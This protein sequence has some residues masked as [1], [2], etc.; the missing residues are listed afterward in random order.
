MKC[1]FR[2]SSFVLSAAFFLS[3]FVAATQSAH[4]QSGS[5]AIQFG[6]VNIGTTSA[7]IAV[8]LAFNNVS[9]LGAVSVMTAGSSGLDFA[10]VGLDS[11][12]LNTNGVGQC[13]VN[14]TFTPRFS[15]ARY[16]AVV[17][18][19]GSGSVVATTY[20][21]GTGVGP[22]VNFLAGTEIPVPTSTLAYPSLVAVDGNGDVFIA[23]SGNNRV[24][25]EAFSNGAFSESIIMTSALAWPSGIAV[26]ASGC[27]Y[28]ADSGNNR[29]LK[30]TLSAG[31]YVESTIQTSTLNWPLAV[32]V[33]ASGN[34]YIADSGNNRILMES[35]SAGGYT[36]STVSTSTLSYPSGVAVDS[37][38]NIYIADS[39]NNRALVEA[40]SAGSYEE[41]TVPT[42]ALNSP[43]SVSVDD[44]NNIYIADSGNNRV[45]KEV[46]VA[47]NYT[48][49]TVPSSA[50]NWPSSVVVDGLGNVYIA[51]SGNNR[52]L[53]EDLADPPSLS[54]AATVPGSTS[55]DSPRT[56]TLENIGNAVLS[57]P[58]PN[59]GSNPSIT[60][61]FSL[62]MSGASACPYVTV[63]P[64]AGT[65]DAGQSCSLPTSFVPTEAGTFS[66]SLV[67]TDNSLN[68]AASQTIQLSGVGTGNTQ[69]TINFSPIG[70]QFANSN[71]ALVASASSG[72]LVS[73]SST[74]PTICTVT[75]TAASLIAAGTCT[76]LASQSG[77]STYAAA[78]TVTQGFTVNL[79]PQTITF[80]TI[81]TQIINTS[82]PVAL[83]ATA[84]SGLPV[85]FLST[86]S[87]VC[88]ITGST[89]VL[90]ATG[91]CTIQASQAGDGIVYAA[92]STV[93]QSFA[94]ASANQVTATA[95]GSVNI[96]GTSSQIN[97]NLVFNV[98]G[99]VASATV[100][101][102]GATGLDFTKAGLG[103]CAVGTNYSAGSAC[104]VSV[105]FTPSFSGAR[106]GAVVLADGSGNSLA[107]A[108]LEGTGIGPQIDF[109]PG[110]EST[111]P[112]STLAYSAGVAQDDIGNLYI[113][114]TG[115]NRVLKETASA[116]GYT[117]S[118][119]PSSALT[120]PSGVA[121]DAAGN[122]YIADTGNSRV[123]KETLSAGS[124]SEST[125]P[126]SPLSWPSGVAVDGSGNVYVADT[127][128]NRVLIEAL[129]LGNYIESVI[130]T[131]PLTY[132]GA[133]AVDG[134]GNLYIAD[135]GNNRILMETVS[136]GS[137]TESV[138]Q[139][140]TLNYPESIAVDGDSN[141]FIADTYNNRVLKETVS[142]GSYVESTVSTSTLSGPSGVVVASNGN[143]AIA[144]TY[145]NRIL[146]EDLADAPS[147]SFAPTAPG[148]A[149]SDSPQTIALENNGNAVLSFSVPASGTDPNIPSN[150]ALNSGVMS[151]C[152]LLA[153]GA[154]A[155]GTLASGQSC[156]L[157]ISFTP[158]SSG[159]FSAPLI[160]TDN[161]LNLS[162][163][164]NI[165][166][167][168]TGTG[169]TQQ[170]I[171]FSPISP[172]FA[173]SFLSLVA[174]ASSG[175]PVSFVSATPSICSVSG[176]SASL[177]TAGT[178]TIQAN[179][180]GSP[181]YAPALAVAQS[182]TVTLLP[183]TITFAPISNQIINKSAP[184]ILSA[185]ASSGLPIVFTTTT[186]SVCTV[187]GS[188][189][190][191]AA[192]GTCTI[193]ANQ[194]GDGVVYAAAPTAT[195]SFTVAAVNAMTSANLGSVNVG[196]TSSPT[197]VTLN[198]YSAAIL[199]SISVLTQGATGLNF[200]SAGGGSCVIGT[201]YSAGSSCTVNVTFTPTYPGSLYGAVSLLDDSGSVIAGG[202]LQGTGVGPQVIFLPGGESTLSTSALAYP[203]QIAVDASGNVYIADTGNNRVLKETFSLGGYVESSIP[204][205]ALA[206]PTGVAIDGSGNLFI[207]DTVN[208]RVLRETLADGQFVESTVPTSALQNPAAVAADGNGN[209]YIADY[210]NN[211]VLME[212]PSSGSYSETV[213]PTSALSFPSGVAADASGNVYIADTYNSRV[214]KES[215]SSGSYTESTI[216][217]SPLSYPFGVA[218]D[219]EGNVYIADS[220]NNR[221]LK[222]AP[223]AGSYIET[224]VSTSTLNAPLEISGSYNGNLY[225]A[226]TYNNRVLKEDFADPPSLVFAN[227]VPGSTSSDSPQIVT[228]ENAG[229]A[230]LNFPV[231]SSGS[232]P[233]ISS[234]FTLGN[235]GARTCPLITSGVSSAGAL[236]AGQS[237]LLPV[238]FAPSEAGPIS[239]TLNLSDNTLDATVSQTIELNGFATGNT[240]QTIS[241]AS[242]SAQS[243]LSNVPLTATASS[244][245]T[246]SLA[247]TSPAICTVA[248][249]AASL[250]AAGNCTIQ[251]S[252][253][254]NSV[255]SPAPPVTQNFVVNLLPQTISFV[256]IATQMINTPVPLVAT[257]SSGLPVIFSSSTPSVCTVASSTA[258]LLSVGT[259][260][261]QATQPGDG[262]VFAPAPTATQSFTVTLKGN[263]SFGSINVGST[264]PAIS[265]TLDVYTAA[266]LGSVSVSTQG[267]SGL[268]F[269]V[270]SGGGTCAVGASYNSG[271]TCTVSA[272]FT[273]AHSGSRYGAVSLL[274]GS[275]NVI[276]TSYLQG[277]G[278]GPQ[279][280]FPPG[281]EGTVPNGAYYVEQIALD[282]NN[283][284]YLADA[285]GN[286]IL[287]E[288]FTSGSYS[289]SVIQTS[290]LA[291][292]Y[293]VSIDGN[294]N[295]Y[296]ADSGNNRILKETLSSGNYIE[297][298]ISTSALAYPD[299]VAVDGNGN[300]YISDCDNNRVLKETLSWGQYTESVV[301][302]SA[303]NCPAEIAVDGFGN[304]YFT[305]YY[306]N[307]VL[308]EAPSADT[309]QETTIPTS[310]LNYPNGIAVDNSGDIYVV[311]SNPWLRKETVSAGKYTE[312]I[313]PTSE[314]YS[315]QAVA[316]DSSGNIYIANDGFGTLLKED[317]VDPPSLSF[318]N[319]APG[320][321]SSDSPQ[322]VTVEN[323]GN[324]ILAFP[325]PSNGSNPAISANFALTSN[326]AQSCPVIESG[327]SA[328]GMLAAGQSCLL[329]LSFTP[330]QVGS[331][332]G[333]LVLTDNALN[334]AA[335]QTIQLSGSG[336]EGTQQTIT[337]API[338]GQL[339]VQYIS[340][341]ATA[342]SGLSVTLTSVTPSVCWVTSSSS[343]WLAIAGTCTIQAN[344]AGNSVY[345]PAPTVTQSFTVNLNSQTIEYQQVPPQIIN[346]SVPTT[347]PIWSTSGLPISLASMTP[348]VC[349]VPASTPTGA[350]AILL[351]AAGTCTIQASQPGDGAL[352]APAAAVTLSF[353]VEPPPPA[354]STRF[355]AANIG[356]T[357]AAIA[358]TLSFNA[359]ASLGG[360]SVVTQGVT[361]LDF[362]NASGGT[363]TIGRNYD[364]GASCTVNVTFSPISSGV[365]YGGVSLFDDSGN[366][367]ATAYVE[368]IGIGPQI[369]FVPGSES[370]VST[371]ALNTPFGVAVD[372][373]GNL[374]IADTWNSRLIK[375][376]VTS[377]GYVESTI[378]VGTPYPGA[379][380]IDGNGNLYIAD[381]SSNLVLKETVSANGYSEMVLQTSTLDYPDALAV[382]GSGNL[383]IT[384]SGNNRVLI[385][386]ST[387]TGYAETTLPTSALAYPNG[388]AVDGNGNIYI[389]DTDNDRVLKEGVSLSGYT[390]STLPT[391]AIGPMGVA[392][393]AG[394]SLY[395][396]D[397]FFQSFGFNSPA[398]SVLKE[399]LSAGTYIES[400][401]ATSTLSEPLGIAVDS[402]G[403]VYI[404]DTGNNRILKEDYADPPSLSFAST[405]V[406]STSGDS[407]QTVTFENVGNAA[408]TF[409]IPTA[410][411]NPIVPENFSLYSAGPQSCPLVVAGS[412]TVGILS[413][414]QNCSLVVSFMPDETGNLNG[415][416]VLTDN[417]LNAS[418][419]S[420]ATQGIQ[421]SGT[422][423]QGDQ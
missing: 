161:A 264:S 7:P 211:R 198:V 345:A 379:V 363:C 34:V 415:T 200:A 285:G 135:S 96:G 214:L 319:T 182:F 83:A 275:G 365:R 357:S 324:A 101:T 55:S 315:A 116:N 329:P 349:S 220:Y 295:V 312:E 33:D 279:V 38:G 23:D 205:S 281:T 28:I 164:Q 123:L 258:T 184:V 216:P 118:T 271:S 50:L 213:I 288:T 197:P 247:S 35:L 301:P 178:C 98:S 370:T 390:E 97:V 399:T 127:A 11:C 67:L 110:T 64:S 313:V 336:V 104:S 57:F 241:F 65:L 15:G 303:L 14:V 413:S 374:Y 307:R 267:L 325:I 10:S 232:N 283:D 165:M 274:D 362:A 302:T 392:V 37:N 137:Y 308:M 384:D 130:P 25:K 204:T 248:G 223:S 44:A 371:S 373:N 81:P 309:Y 419:P 141:V 26:D 323:T 102:R 219:G 29:V 111:I 377:G 103:T 278:V 70:S 132:P 320:T 90:V 221:I 239:G 1:L 87:S 190:V 369:E 380:A 353:T 402:R 257:A 99:T 92:A 45:L 124:Y 183:Q 286:Q 346:T 277:M 88:T 31:S 262:A 268:D 322:I 298:T 265:V 395:I 6:S 410:G 43:A 41:T 69:Q 188:T 316:V 46:P 305:D 333:S 226:D 356:T 108:Y 273:P 89:A 280:N 296:I 191:L 334:A 174:T 157:P 27:I 22:Q 202:Y 256:S 5:S 409:P 19:D 122:V 210:G 106:Y 148:S 240:Q 212:S 292:P 73:F 376:T 40:P 222:E 47:G 245:L 269:A 250:V 36:E 252:Q 95:F 2:A 155:P 180:P 138:V 306:N 327:S 121:V 291:G 207:A 254:G 391:S 140:S 243:V 61:N 144:D 194:P 30:E 75:G 355:G 389:A 406:G 422:G 421:L 335:S 93:T 63:G 236:A 310:P 56:V 330:T 414:G 321:T 412:S 147:L 332:S 189:A 169:S 8:T 401:L 382:D 199:G 400:S 229:N 192:T 151:A 233:T 177:M 318:T 171:T 238:N 230:M 53:K 119:I 128:N 203:S 397:S 378:P 167:S 80:A 156:L 344:Q 314:L 342:S 170:T 385:E 172:Q 9:T 244:G 347:L 13:S 196:S 159:V 348:S 68:A 350:P 331:L 126:T 215:L 4:G 231:P 134:N 113:A 276:A 261:I 77:N 266:T 387:A 39:G 107:T 160:L 225:V 195:Q 176:L 420:F 166:L 217:T 366:P 12:T 16:G 133:V 162:A 21:Q 237:C 375:E 58:V 84:S 115:N 154:S 300:I 145:D 153:A 143:I 259:C 381:P 360:V 179:Q 423:T 364:A 20:L 403:N 62:N 311:D 120:S 100:L 54:F 60:Q 246:V 193:Q 51:D 354:T 343:V 208:N 251:A 71:L 32:A 114:D 405:V 418:G 185:T 82:V 287:K 131:S 416:L 372:G 394:G 49:S 18:A 129:S 163:S 209:I 297:S 78:V 294:G 91:T 337:F 317:Y 201:S 341:T 125:V 408:L 340:V 290:S 227:A 299:G 105:T 272:T 86:T 404:A 181:V 351:L 76:I 186:S 74:T 42:S 352:Y 158:G 328:M 85:N 255:Y 304:I 411:S 66:G 112:T 368:G 263:A 282:A 117:E 398:N 361:G 289:E 94:V 338:S 59:G 386:A 109:L 142:S 187:S 173:G 359:A 339:P 136:S 367:I 79:Q 358:V 168:G 242:I 72:L 224:L 326:G 253:P 383:Y 284:V 218:V 150:F 3:H 17:L 388:I 149:S 24:L 139:T 175:L 206:S 407:P 293:A 235:T 52:V 249:T 393:D 152:P 417:A 270:S 234:N 48:E 146:K 396:T 260:T 228:V